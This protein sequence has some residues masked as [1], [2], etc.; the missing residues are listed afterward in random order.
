[1]LLTDKNRR[2]YREYARATYDMLGLEEPL[3]CAA[4][5]PFIV[6]AS[7]LKEMR[8]YVE[9]AK[10]KS[11]ADV[12]NFIGYEQFSVYNII[13]SFLFWKKR[14]EY[15]WYVHD[16]D[17]EWD[18]FKPAPFFGQWGDKSVFE[19]RMMLPKPFIANHL[20]N[21]EKDFTIK[22]Y[23]QYIAR[24]MCWKQPLSSIVSAKNRSELSNEIIDIMNNGELCS[25]QDNKFFFQE[26][27]TFESFDLNTPDNFPDRTVLEELIYSRKLRIQNCTHNYLFL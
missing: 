13:C 4:Y 26:M 21:F 1:M 12:F 9:V 2:T 8:E 25:R 10:G 15:R 20:W 16:I 27:F 23:S 18:G 24:A 19:K 11:F 22:I 17:K 14:N 5:F 3:I 6:R 7:H